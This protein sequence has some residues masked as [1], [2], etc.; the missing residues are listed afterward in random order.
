MEDNVFDC[1]N[2]KV[3]FW[4]VTFCEYPKNSRIL[5]I[6]IRIVFDSILSIPHT[7]FNKF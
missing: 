3:D 7:Q 2:V 5:F 1:S 6:F 4:R